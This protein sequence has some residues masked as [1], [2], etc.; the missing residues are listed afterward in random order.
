MRECAHLTKT[1]QPRNL[2]YVQLGI[3]E[4]TNR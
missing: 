2:G 4:V 3:I 1:E